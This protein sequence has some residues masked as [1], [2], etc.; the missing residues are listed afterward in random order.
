MIVFDGSRLN[1]TRFGR[2][3][4]ELYIDPVSAVVIREGLSSERGTDGKVIQRKEGAGE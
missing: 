2:R 4:S 3:V 1:P